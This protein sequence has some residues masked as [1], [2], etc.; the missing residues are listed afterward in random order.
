MRADQ[1]K[2]NTKM[3]PYKKRILTPR[4]LQILR[5]ILMKFR[6]NHLLQN[7]CSYQTLL[8]FYQFFY[9]PFD[10]KIIFKNIN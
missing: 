4:L 1:L 5:C 10:L 6:V 3:R 8:L 7:L 2:S 9:F